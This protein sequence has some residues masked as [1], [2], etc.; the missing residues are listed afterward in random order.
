MTLESSGNILNIFG[1]TQDSSASLFDVD[2][3]VQGTFS[4]LDTSGVNPVTFS[5][6]V[7][8]SGN[9]VLGLEMP[10]IVQNLSIIPSNHIL[11]N[12]NGFTYA[13]NVALIG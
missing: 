2:V 3:N 12:I 10:T 7:D 13:I 9:P 1:V 11:V 8:V 4:V 5:S 6:V